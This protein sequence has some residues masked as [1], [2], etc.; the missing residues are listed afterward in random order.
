MGLSSEWVGKDW[1][2]WAPL[3]IFLCV[4]SPA[5]GRDRPQL[6]GPGFLATPEGLG[7]GL[8]I[9]INLS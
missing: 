6:T 5:L 7:W 2:P 1:K 8:R 4:R 9:K 3:S